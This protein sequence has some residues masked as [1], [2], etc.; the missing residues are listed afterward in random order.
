MTSSI[1]VSKREIEKAPNTQ[2]PQMITTMTLLR[3]CKKVGIFKRAKIKFTNNTMTPTRPPKINHS[4]GRAP[5]GN[6]TKYMY[7]NTATKAI[8]QIISK[9]N[10]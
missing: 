6:N 2:T 8:L 4:F 1:A 9:T 10:P 5:R 3:I 7:P